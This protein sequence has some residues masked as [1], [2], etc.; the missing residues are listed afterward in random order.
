MKRPGQLPK[1]VDFLLCLRLVGFS[2]VSTL[3][4]HRLGV[5]KSHLEIQYIRPKMQDLN[6]NLD[7]LLFD[8]FLVCYNSN[9]WQLQSFH[10][11]LRT[12]HL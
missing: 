12:H 8:R 6:T 4:Q 1:I 9:L 11:Q 7:L 5:Q 2:G 3:V 10:K